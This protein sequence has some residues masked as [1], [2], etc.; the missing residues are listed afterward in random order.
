MATVRTWIK[1]NWRTL[2]TAITFMAL[3]VFIY[4]LRNQIVTTIRNLEHINFWILL[5]MIPL[6]GASYHFVALLYRR[7]FRILDARVGYRSLYRI[8]LELN[9]VNLVFPS[10]GFSGFSYFGLRLRTKGVRTGK[11]TLVQTMRFILLFISFQIMLFV[12]L[13]ILALNGRASNFMILIAG[14]LAT[15]LFA[16]TTAL[17]FIIGSEKRID[18][19]FT[20]I[21]KV[22]NRIIQLVRPKYPETINV[23]KARETFREYHGSYKILRTNYRKL[24][25]PLLYALAINGAEILTIYVVF[26]AFGQ[27]VNPGAV[28][29]AYAVA[30]FAG[31]ISVLPGG[32]G[33][34]E[35]LMTGV[36]AAGGVPAS[37][38]LP[39]IVT[40]RVLSISIQVIPGGYY[41]Q[42]AVREAHVHGK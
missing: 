19:F 6:Q 28:I 11:A 36:L 18:A 16:G 7:L 10:G 23:S 31:L 33:I 2:V 1:H 42:R 41:Y 25:K 20:F 40:Y 17:T 24:K 39:I 29:I 26:V 14:S 22:I 34:Y 12:G 5:F 30:N 27:W 4:V 37:L 8:A 15:L 13:F 32:I 35:A 3:A 9:F 38:S 21:T